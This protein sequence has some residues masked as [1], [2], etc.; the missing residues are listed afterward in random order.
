MKIFNYLKNNFYKLSFYFFVFSFLGYLFEISKHFV[1]YH[2]FVNRGTYYGPIL[3]IYGL[4]VVIGVVVLSKF[5][6]KPFRLFI[7][8]G[9]LC[10]IIEFILS[11]IAEL[12][13]HLRWWDY[14]KYPLNI[15]GRIC[16]YSFLLFGL[17]GVIIIKYIL[18]LFEAFY[19]KF[20]KKLFKIMLIICY[21]IFLIDVIYTF[22]N[23]H[24]GK[25]ISYKV[26]E[27]K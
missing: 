3:P 22:Y 5:K 11:Y 18:P 25:S 7:F 1:L 26:Q 6:N 27:K 10:N 21:L 9:L 19:K 24:T 16:L 8:S 14:T 20:N 17:F 4:C 2:V 23:P 12:I 15:D 13:F